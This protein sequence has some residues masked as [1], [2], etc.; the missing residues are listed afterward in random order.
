ML[1]FELDRLSSSKIGEPRAPVLPAQQQPPLEC[2]A[3]GTVVEDLV[4]Y[5]SKNLPIPSRTRRGNVV[6]MQPHPEFLLGSARER[7]QS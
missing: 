7:Q 5:A 3:R 2:S 1:T 4:Q 6:R